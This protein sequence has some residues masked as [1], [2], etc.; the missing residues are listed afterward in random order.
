[1]TVL[2]VRILLPVLVNV[3]LSVFFFCFYFNHITLHIGSNSTEGECVNPTQMGKVK[4]K[5]N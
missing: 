4:N 2:L 1:M 3:L 5:N